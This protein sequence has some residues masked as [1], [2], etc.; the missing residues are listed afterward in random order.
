[1]CTENY[2]HK[3]KSVVQDLCAVVFQVVSSVS[4]SV[5][6]Y[7][8]CLRL[9]GCV[10]LFTREYAMTLISM[11]AHIAVPSDDCPTDESGCAF[12]PNCSD[13][14]YS[15]LPDCKCEGSSSAKSAAGL[16]KPRLEDNILWK[17]P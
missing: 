6:L 3:K 4:V 17:D 5:S 11:G 15:D 14:S 1:M 13:K 16:F 8:P 12:W 2:H 7:K 9:Y 10:V